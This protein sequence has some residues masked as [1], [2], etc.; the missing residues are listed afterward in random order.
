MLV[1]YSVPLERF[2][3]LFN[4]YPTDVYN[5]IC[6]TWCKTSIVLPVDIQRGS[7]NKRQ[8][9]YCTVMPLTQWRDIQS[10]P[11]FPHCRGPRTRDSSVNFSPAFHLPTRWC[12]VGVCCVCFPRGK[13]KKCV[14]KKRFLHER[15]FYREARPFIKFWVIFSLDLHTCN[16]LVTSRVNHSDKWQVHPWQPEPVLS[17]YPVLRGH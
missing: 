10:V 9:K 3:R 12:S 17:G 8:Q 6:W 5:F 16:K 13:K 2:D 14:E 11:R 7:C 4:P 15:C 1:T